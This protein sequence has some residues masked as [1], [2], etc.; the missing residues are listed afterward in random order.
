MAVFVDFNITYTMLFFVVDTHH[1]LVRWKLVTQ[2]GIDGYSRLVLF[3]RCSTNNR[4][5]TMY[6]VFLSAVQ[7][8]H[9]PSRIRTDQGRENILV[10][11]HMLEKRGADRRS[12]ITGSSV[13]NQRIERLWRD[14]HGSVTMFYYRLFYHLENCGMLDP[15][16]EIHLFSVHY[17]FVPRINR[18]L[19]EF[20]DAWNSHKIRTASNKSPQQLFTAG[21]MI[22]QHSQ[23]TAL[24]FFDDVQDSYGIDND[25]PEADPE[26]EDG[27]VSV[28]EVNINLSP[29]DYRTLTSTIDPLAP[30][31][32]FGIDL[33]E[34]VVQYI[35]SV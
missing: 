18:S 15:L 11:Q 31:Q 35:Q 30:S 34:S 16:N 10:A 28:P 13:H 17:V 3:L 12:V 26:D 23:L 5:S 25:G 21:M 1:K 20:K 9:L 22:L 8:Y 6:D 24:D 27:T 4:A 7:Q 19:Q 29:A 32:D 2:G 33:Y 14:V